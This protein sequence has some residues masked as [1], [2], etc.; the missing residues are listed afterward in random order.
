MDKAGR[1]GLLSQNCEQEFVNT[2]IW[3]LFKNRF[4]SDTTEASYWSDIQEFCRMTGKSFDKAGDAEVK[5]YYEAMQARIL[6]GRISPLT[7]TK[8]FRELHSVAQ[9]I[10]EHDGADSEKRD[11]FAPYLKHLAKEEPL[12]RS[13][14]VE[15]M[16]A[17]LKAASGDLMAY[18]IL[19]LMYR[20]GLSST[21][22]TEL[23]GEDDFALYDDGAY[24]FLP[25]RREPCYIPDDAWQILKEYMAERERHPSLFY[26]RRGNRLNSMYIS[27]MMK[28]YCMAAGI[29]GVS[30][31]AV[32]NCCAF[33]LFSY[34]ATAAQTAAQMGR[35]ELQIRRYKGL[36]YQE[37]L[38]KKANDLVKMRIEKPQP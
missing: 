10:I 16:D 4:K 25:R 29:R 1:A 37:N 36:S 34:G 35:T 14:P 22:I 33:N 9:F 3:N 13:V 8:K 11:P 23:D 2:E 24:V 12:A 21:E 28:K 31:E 18:T 27:R 20:A 7:L 38:R 26:N 5:R 19:T 6:E 17:L 15:D 30:A 32:R